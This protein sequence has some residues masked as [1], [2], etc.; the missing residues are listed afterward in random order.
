MTPIKAIETSYK[1]HLFRSRLEARWAVLFDELQ[2]EWKY[3]SQGFENDQGDRYLPDFY[4]PTSHTWVEVKGDA[5]ALG[6]DYERMARL[7][8]F[9]GCLPYFADSLH[10]SRGLLLLGDI[11]YSAN[12]SA[13]FSHPLSQ[14]SKGLHRNWSVMAPGTVISIGGHSDLH[15][16]MDVVIES[17]AESTPD[18]WIV[19]TRELNTNLGW[20]SVGDAYRSAR[21]SRF[22]HGQSGALR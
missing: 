13:T 14:H 20:D 15:E 17:G 9:G 19:E 5:V 1:G 11:P 6:R 22:E 3:E 12:A 7:L 16:M 4:L 8:D 18:L 10:S 21:S 2:I